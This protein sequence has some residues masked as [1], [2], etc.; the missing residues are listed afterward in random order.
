M[1]ER[2]QH[3][4]WVRPVLCPVPL[5]LQGGV[6]GWLLSATGHTE[7]LSFS[8]SGLFEMQ[9]SHLCL[10]R[11]YWL[12]QTMLYIWMK[13]IR[14]GLTEA[15]LWLNIHLKWNIWPPILTF[16]LLLCKCRPTWDKL[17]KAVFSFVNY[18]KHSGIK[19]CSKNVTDNLSALSRVGGHSKIENCFGI[20]CWYIK[21]IMSLSITAP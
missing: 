17:G 12:P 3:P 11:Y 18:W 8:F 9:L 10:S 15:R 2:V 20:K 4:A 19:M 5:C 16:S 6:Y 14:Y 21:Y 13:K 1:R 7:G